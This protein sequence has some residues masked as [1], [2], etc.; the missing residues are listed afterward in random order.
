MHSWCRGQGRVGCELSTITTLASA[1][2]A[3]KTWDLCFI[4][5][6][7]HLVDLASKVGLVSTSCDV[8]GGDRA[9]LSIRRT[10]PKKAATSSIVG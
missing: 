9:A 4:K 10:P 7:C 8:A 6:R 2:E 1:S 5:Q 3:G